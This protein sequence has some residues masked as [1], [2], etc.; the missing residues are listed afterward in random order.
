MAQK[1][2]ETD[3]SVA[4]FIEKFAVLAVRQ[5]VYGG[6]F[7]LHRGVFGVWRE[8]RQPRLHPMGFG[9][10]VVI[11]TH[12]RPEIRSQRFGKHS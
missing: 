2:I 4:D 10:G 1:T 11:G 9:F 3:Q 6:A 7:L 5:S 8:S 12:H